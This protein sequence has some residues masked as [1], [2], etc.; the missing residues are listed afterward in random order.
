MELVNNDSRFLSIAISYRNIT[1][2]SN[3][4]KLGYSPE[5][6]LFHFDYCGKTIFD[7]NPMP[8]NAILFRI[9]VDYEPKVI[10]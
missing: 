5:R 3:T 7:C 4:L 8:M 2:I 10:S 6:D 9:I 1:S